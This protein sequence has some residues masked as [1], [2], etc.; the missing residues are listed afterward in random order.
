MILELGLI[1]ALVFVTKKK[2]VVPMTTTGNRLYNLKDID[3]SI[4]GAAYKK[5]YDTV[6]ESVANEFGVPFALLKAHAIAESSLNPNAF[7]DE[8]N[9]KPERQGWGSRGLMQILWWPNSDRFKKYG[10]PDK[11]LG[12]DGIR[13]FEPLV[14]VRIAGQLIKDNLN[15]CAGNLRDAVNMYNTGKK[16]S[17]YKAPNNYVDKVIN[18]YNKILGV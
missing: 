5:D 3:P 12:V 10:Y 18:Y 15:A 8:S 4:Q 2:E 1:T 7:R 11:D 14:N 9:S 6:F 16:E 13:M 17:Q